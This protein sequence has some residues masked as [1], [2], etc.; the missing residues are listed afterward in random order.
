MDRRRFLVLSMGVPATG[1]ALQAGGRWLPEQGVL[2]IPAV[3]N[4]TVFQVELVNDLNGAR[5]GPVP[6]RTYMER[7]A[8]RLEWRPFGD[9]RFDGDELLA[10][11]LDT[12]TRLEVDGTPVWGGLFP[13]KKV[14]C[15]IPGS[16]AASLRDADTVTLCFG[17]GPMVVLS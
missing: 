5:F 12:V 3:V 9:L 11:G 15:P 14:F 1:L 16:G 17:G 7:F 13:G 2:D 10:A 4:E 6:V 8:D